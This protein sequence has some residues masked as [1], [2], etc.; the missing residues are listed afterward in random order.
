MPYI[1][2]EIPTSALITYRDAIEMLQ[3]ATKLLQAAKGLHYAPV[4]SALKS[5]IVQEAFQAVKHAETLIDN[6]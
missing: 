1:P 6:L 5:R 2:D 3:T 4:D